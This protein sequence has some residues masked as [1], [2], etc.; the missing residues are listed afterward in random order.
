V[1]KDKVLSLFARADM[2]GHYRNQL[3]VIAQQPRKG[4]LTF[5]VTVTDRY[6][7]P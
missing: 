7:Q 6:V 1:T 3:E 5:T 4:I 2:I